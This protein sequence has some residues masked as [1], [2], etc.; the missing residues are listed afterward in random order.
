M[1]LVARVNSL[2]LKFLL[3][4]FG[5]WVVDGFSAWSESTSAFTRTRRA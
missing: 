3:L 4:P 2:P 5:G 1:S